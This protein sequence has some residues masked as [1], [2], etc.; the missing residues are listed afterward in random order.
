M[1]RVA[2]AAADLGTEVAALGQAQVA[3]P[4]PRR[5]RMG[6]RELAHDRERRA[7]ELVGAP[8][9]PVAIGLALRTGSQVKKWRPCGRQAHAADEAA[10]LRLADGD[11]VAPLDPRRRRR[12]RRSTSVSP[13]AAIATAI[14]IFAHTE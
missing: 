6:A 3:D 4:D 11:R 1:G 12:R 2:D 10:G 7:H 13:V 8:A 5:A 9:S 14:A